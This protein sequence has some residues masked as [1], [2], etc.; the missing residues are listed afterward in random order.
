MTKPVGRNTIA[1]A[2]VV[3][4]AVLATAGPAMAH[5]VLS[6]PTDQAPAVETD[7]RPIVNDHE[8]YA[9]ERFRVHGL[10]YSN[11]AVWTLAFVTGGPTEYYTLDG[12]RVELTGDGSRSVS[13]GDIFT[14]VMTITGAQGVSDPE[15]TLDEV[16]V[17]GR[18]SS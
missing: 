2:I 13:Q 6:A 3:G 8:R 9:G 10:V 5:P 12:A 7:I 4:A 1:A 15:V 18:G 16:T 11:A 14:G 17:I